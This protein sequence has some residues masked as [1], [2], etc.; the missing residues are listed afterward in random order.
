[1]RL[2]RTVAEL[3]EQLSDA[4]AGHA[5]TIGL[6]PTMGAL[7][8]GHLSLIRAAAHECDLVVVSVFVNPTQFDEPADLAAYPRNEDEDA[9]LAVEAGAGLLF[10][11][12]VAELYPDGFATSVEVVGPLTE[13]FE[14]AVRGSG[15]F[16]GVTTVVAKLLGA[17]L[18]DI[19][20]FG[21]KD[22]QQLVVIRRL[23]SDL[24]LPVRIAALPTARDRDGLALSSRNAR[25]SAE[26]RT[27]AR[28][29]PEALDA[30]QDAA[31]DGERSA[32]AL[33][34]AAG[35]ALA[36]RRIEPEYLAL[37]DPGTLDPV[38]A[39]NAEALL[40]VAARVGETR[41][42]DNAL[43]EPAQAAG[44]RA[45]HDNEP[46]GEAIAPCSA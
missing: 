38:E 33:L 5:R 43:L 23:V 45:D 39:L 8:D 1:M 36:A 18:P 12:P 7:H 24:N 27:R 20:Y 19:A 44:S 31:R 26:E 28:G 13:R 35:R 15:H 25:L 41:L 11:P 10:A 21:Q 30:A 6:V 46:Q 34:A 17:V 3:R 16:R 29:I 4:R 40:L 14:G 37:V 42:I 2:V 32:A 22:A 9:A